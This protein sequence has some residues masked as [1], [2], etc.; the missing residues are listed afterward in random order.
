MRVQRPIAGVLAARRG[1]MSEFA[2]GRE[3]VEENSAIRFDRL[4]HHQSEVA[5]IIDLGQ[6]VTRV[7]GLH[8]RVLRDIRVLH[9]HVTLAHDVQN[10]NGDGHVFERILVVRAIE[11]E[12]RMSFGM[13]AL[14]ERSIQSDDT[15]VRAPSPSADPIWLLTIPEVPCLSPSNS[16]CQ[17]GP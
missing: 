16:R 3:E 12:R 9:Q 11:N 2:A 13:R 17:A 1:S 4:R 14:I 10:R 5:D 15:S 6:P 7:L 8:R